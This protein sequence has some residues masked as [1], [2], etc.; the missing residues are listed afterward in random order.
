MKENAEL[1]AMQQEIELMSG[2]QVVEDMV[3][4]IDEVIQ[5]KRNKERQ[6]FNIAENIIIF[7]EFYD[8]Y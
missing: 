1:K 4:G 2:F 7:D 6:K 3:L 8:Q 5:D